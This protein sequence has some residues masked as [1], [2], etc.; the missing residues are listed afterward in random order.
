MGKEEM[1]DLALLDLLPLRMG[2]L[3]TVG[4]SSQTE[5][6][7]NTLSLGSPC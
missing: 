4:I 3:F 7:E 1:A 6:M 5:K 2:V